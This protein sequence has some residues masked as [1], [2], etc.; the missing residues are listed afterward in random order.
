MCNNMKV[1]KGKVTPSVRKILTSQKTF[2]NYLADEEALAAQGQSLSTT[3][4]QPLNPNPPT[5]VPQHHHSPC[6][7]RVI[8]Q[9]AQ[10]HQVDPQPP[11]LPSKPSLRASL[12][13][14]RIHSTSPL[15]PQRHRRRHLT[16]RPH[17]AFLPRQLRA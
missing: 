9:K 7:L 5:P 17:L 12:T 8:L 4:S 11:T 16:P 2:A 3:S 14:T 1:S 6:R 15:R 10:A 13:R